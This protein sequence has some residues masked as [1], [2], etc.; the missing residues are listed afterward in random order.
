ME[1]IFKKYG[2]FRKGFDFGGKLPPKNTSRRWYE[3]EDTEYDPVEKRFEGVDEATKYLVEHGYGWEDTTG[4]FVERMPS[5]GFRA[6]RGARIIGS[7]MEGDTR[8]S[9]GSALRRFRG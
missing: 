7:D 3:R 2:I 1:E 6:L 9:E 8:F 5:V 4:L